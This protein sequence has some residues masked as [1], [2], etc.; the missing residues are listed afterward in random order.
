MF[1]SMSTVARAQRAHAR[2]MRKAPTANEAKLW[3][4]LRRR[5]VGDLRFRRQSP[6]GPYIVDFVCLRHRLII[7]ADGPFHD[8][9]H[10]QRRDAWFAGQGFRVL[11]FSND[12][13]ATDHKSVL[14]EILRAVEPRG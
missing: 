9:A 4:L 2:R 11:R 10:D 5:Q 14:A 7:E 3:E 13:I 6:L 12:M 1:H 8:Q